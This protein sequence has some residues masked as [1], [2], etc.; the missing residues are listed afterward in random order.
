MKNND[1]KMKEILRS[2][3]KEEAEETIAEVEADESLKDISLPEDMDEKL[4]N[5]IQE[6]EDGQDVYERLSEKDKEALRIGR[7]MQMLR[8]MGGDLEDAEDEDGNSGNKRAD[9]GGKK[10]TVRYR[11]KKKMRKVYVLVALVAVLVLGMGMTSIGGAPFLTGLMERVIGD[12]GMVQV[13]TE[14]ENEGSVEVDVSSEAAIYDDIKKE[15]G[16]DVV[17]LLYVPE[18]AKLLTSNIDIMLRNVCMLYQYGS[19]I[20][21]YKV[22]LN[23]NQQVHAY[24]I[25]D[26]LLD[27]K[28]IIVSEIPIQIRT[29]EISK[30]KTE[31][32]AQFEYKNAFYIINA[33]IPEEEFMKI[34]KN[35]FFY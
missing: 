2:Q 18:D 9:D 7:E 23:Y 27:E 8:E 19:D 21:E 26:K 16:V 28:E 20:I 5:M 13:D 24:D 17:R 4:Q 34:V 12:R 32:V 1:E 11:K 15:L 3:L 22:I 29:Y 35:L 31:F 10:K 6:Y 33:A 14:R 25:E 30:E